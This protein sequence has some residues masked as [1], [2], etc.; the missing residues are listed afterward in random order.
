LFQ[1]KRIRGTDME[2]TA[3]LLRASNG[4]G[5]MT[6][7]SLRASAN[8]LSEYFKRADKGAEGLTKAV[9]AVASDTDLSALADH[10]RSATKN[11][12][13]VSEKV[14]KKLD[15]VT[16]DLDNSP[17]IYLDEDKVPPRAEL[18]KDQLAD[19][20][21]SWVAVNPEVRKSLYYFDDSLLRKLNELNSAI[22]DAVLEVIER[23]TEDQMGDTLPNI[24][25]EQIQEAIHEGQKT[26]RQFEV[27]CGPITGAFKGLDKLIVEQTAAARL[28]YRAAQEFNLAAAPLIGVDAKVNDLHQTAQ[29][30]ERAGS[31]LKS[32]ADE[33]GNDFKASQLRW[34]SRRYEREARDNQAV[35][36]LYEL[37]VR[38]A[39]LES[40]RHRQRST[41][42]FYAMLA[43]QGAVTIATFSIAM[44]R[45]SFLWGLATAAGLAAVT[46]GAY[47]FVS[48]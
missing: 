14:V 17:L 15:D 45:R 43:A 34:D 37:D 11:G 20:K 27:A 44:R 25:T 7:D 24:S 41:N 42:F 21:S 4:A 36:G 18:S 46:F 10:L 12:L 35:A 23:K 48:M 6:P 30:A 29:A 40:D 1:A 31:T 26:A 22:P 33:F 16:K 39:N 32:A 28:V 5:T 38:K 2:G 8:R 9:G 13:V 3:T 47:V 19:L